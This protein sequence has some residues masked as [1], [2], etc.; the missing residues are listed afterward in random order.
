MP[1]KLLSINGTLIQDFPRVLNI[2]YNFF[3]LVGYIIKGCH[4][5]HTLVST[6]SHLSKF[7][8]LPISIRQSAN[9]YH[10]ICVSGYSQKHLWPNKSSFI[11]L[12]KPK[13]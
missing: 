7:Y 5:F 13:P 1:K 12:L 11:G 9:S 3:D 8:L 4:H 6:Y 2:W 10:G